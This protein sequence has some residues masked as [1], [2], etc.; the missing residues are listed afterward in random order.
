MAC[1]VCHDMMRL[2]RISPVSA[3]GECYEF[4]QCVACGHTHVRANYNKLP[5]PEPRV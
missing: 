5:E 1:E 2:N 4:W 3:R